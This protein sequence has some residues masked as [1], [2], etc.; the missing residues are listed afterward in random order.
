VRNISDEPLR[1]VTAVST[2]VDKDGG[3]IT[4]DQAIIAYNPILPGQTS[5]FKT[6]STTNPAMKQYSV[7]FKELMGGSIETE[8]QRRKR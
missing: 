1:N 8:D 6:M 3:F 5:P 2:W 7:Q 4:S